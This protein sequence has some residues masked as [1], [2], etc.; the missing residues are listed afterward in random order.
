MISFDSGWLDIIRYLYIIYYAVDVII[1]II[2]II[3][4]V[5]QQNSV[6]IF[7][8]LYLSYH[9]IIDIGI[10]RRCSTGS[11]VSGAI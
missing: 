11:G 10:R 8:L 1:Y 6:V 4:H 3:K 2:I 5:L 7:A 9:C